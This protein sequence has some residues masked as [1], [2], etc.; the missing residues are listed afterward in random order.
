MKKRKNTAA[1]IMAAIALFAIIIGIVGTWAIVVF[2]ALSGWGTTEITEAE[3]Q[4]YINNFS[5]SVNTGSWVV[6]DI[7]EAPLEDWWEENAI[8]ENT[9]ED[10][11][12]EENTAGE[13]W[14]ESSDTATEESTEEPTELEA[15]VEIEDQ[16][17]DTS[18]QADVIESLNT[19]EPSE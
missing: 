16:D 12:I 1:K 3:L 15:T 7:P 5:G 11:T 17:I 4:E 19:E 9:T 8:E 2:Q 6:V 10:N 14:T 13:T 18:T